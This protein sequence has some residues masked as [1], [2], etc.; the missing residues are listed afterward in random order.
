MCFN[1]SKVTCSVPEGIYYEIFSTNVFFFISSPERNKYIKW[2]MFFQTLT[3]LVPP[4]ESA[5][6]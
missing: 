6:N 1:K 5:D 4:Y 3:F 2:L